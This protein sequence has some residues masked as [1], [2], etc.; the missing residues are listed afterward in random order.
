[1]YVLLVFSSQVVVEVLLVPN[2]TLTVTATEP[3]ALWCLGAPMV[4]LVLKVTEVEVVIQVTPVHAVK[5]LVRFD[6]YFIIFVPY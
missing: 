1:M 6:S 5:M 2:H 4:P 3:L